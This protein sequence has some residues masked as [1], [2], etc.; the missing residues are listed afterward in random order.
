MPTSAPGIAEANPDL[1]ARRRQPG[2]CSLRRAQASSG[3]TLLELLIV[4]VVIAISTAMVSARL[5]PDDQR[6]LDQDAERLAQVLSVAQEYSSV[7]AETLLFMP[8]REGFQFASLNPPASVAGTGQG[9]GTLRPLRDDLLGPRRWQLEGTQIRIESD[10]QA[11]D[12]LTI[13]PEP[14]LARTLIEL[15]NR[16]SRTLI[17]RR[18]SGRFQMVKP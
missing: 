4:L 16:Q 10:G 14:G 9:A 11:L 5:M 8:S 2:A 1:K 18:Y 12:R 7:R 6:L 17:A 3:F 15:R 13:S